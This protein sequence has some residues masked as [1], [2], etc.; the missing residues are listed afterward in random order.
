VAPASVSPFLTPSSLLALLQ[1]QSAPSWQAT[2]LPTNRAASSLFPNLQPASAAADPRQGLPSASLN[3]LLFQQRPQVQ[4]PGGP[5][6]SREESKSS[7]SPPP[8]G[9]GALTSFLETEHRRRRRGGEGKGA[10]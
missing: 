7:S 5:S 1:H 9:G 6:S 4:P 10:M 8:A 3:A 2:F